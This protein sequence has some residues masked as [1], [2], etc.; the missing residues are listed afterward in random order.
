MNFRG[1]SVFL[2]VTKRNS[3]SNLSYEDEITYCNWR[4]NSDID[5][6]K[7]PKAFHTSAETLVEFLDQT[8]VA[9]LHKEILQSAQ[10]P[11]FLLSQKLQEEVNF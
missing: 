8:A 7:Q 10:Y 5:K 9:D 11:Y 6:E 4:I 2:S 1:K 3:R